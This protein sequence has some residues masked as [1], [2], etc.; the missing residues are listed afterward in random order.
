[1]QVPFTIIG[2]G[3]FDMADFAAEFSTT[4][5]GDTASIAVAKFVRG[6]G[7]DSAF[8]SFVPE[9]S[10]GLLLGIGLVGLAAKQRNPRILPR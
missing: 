7:D 3:S 10:T 4:P 1:M 5:P 8:G 9:P 2:T 6:P